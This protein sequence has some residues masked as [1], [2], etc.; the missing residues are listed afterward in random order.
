[1]EIGEE[2]SARADSRGAG[3]GW[4]VVLTFTQFFSLFLGLKFCLIVF[5]DGERVRC[6][7][8]RTGTI[9]VIQSGRLGH[10][11]GA[12]VTGKSSEWE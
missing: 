2:R 7:D 8:G 9:T 1:M 6:V 10:G 12:L 11:D 5:V 3:V 4:S